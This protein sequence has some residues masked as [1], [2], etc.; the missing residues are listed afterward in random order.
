MPISP[1]ALFTM[2]G[3]GGYPNLRSLYVPHDSLQGL[4]TNF[5]VILSFVSF[6][7]VTG[8]A[9][10]IHHMN[11]ILNL[12]NFDEYDFSSF[13]GC[14]YLNPLLAYT[15]LMYRRIEKK[16]QGTYHQ[17]HLKDSAQRSQ[18]KFDIKTYRYRPPLPLLALKRPLK[19]ALQTKT[20]LVYMGRS[21]FFL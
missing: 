5:S 1:C 8:S 20:P 21:G 19:F 7:R 11:D 17:R 18:L 3:G 4:P 15:K 16:W 9:F 2:L 14:T 6:Y 12:P 13:I 10:L